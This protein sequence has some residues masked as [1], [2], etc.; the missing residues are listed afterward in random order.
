[1]LELLV[2][3]LTIELKSILW[4]L[5]KF[6]VVVEYLNFESCTPHRLIRKEISANFASRVNGLYV[7]CDVI[8]D[9]GSDAWG[10]AYQVE[11]LIKVRVCDLTSN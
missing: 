9:R 7:S 11:L 6:L 3:I 8:V 1:M 2:S 4:K 5:L 10:N